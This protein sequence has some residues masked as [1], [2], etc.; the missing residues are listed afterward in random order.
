MPHVTLLVL[1]QAL[2]SSLSLAAEMLHAAD[3]FHRRR[4]RQRE[5]LQLLYCAP[6]RRRQMPTAGELVLH[7]HHRRPAPGETDLIIL[8][9]LWR[10]PDRTVKQ[11]AA[12]LPWLRQHQMAGTRICAVGSGSSFLAEAGLLEARPATTHWHDFQRFAE[13]YPAVQLQ[14][15]HLITRSGNLYCAASI[16]A[17]ADLMMHFIQELY[18]LPTAR[19]VESHFSPE[20]RSPYEQQLYSADSTLLHHDEDMVRAQD[21]LRQ[22]LAQSIR[23]EELAQ[24]L[25]LS[26]RSLNRRFRAATGQSPQAWLNRQRLELARDMLRH[27]NLAIAEIAWQCGFRQASHFTASFRQYMQQTP[28]AY[29][30]AV[31]GKLFSASP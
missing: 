19:E 4:H 24:A 26:L 10:K 29:R 7:T 9:A 27:T 3:D 8:P 1:E 20:I 15:R 11:H 2:V 13:H 17:V 22:R 30:E 5:R 18:D 23:I 16:N 6:D 25:S 21:W 12:L 31:R 14:R 28:R